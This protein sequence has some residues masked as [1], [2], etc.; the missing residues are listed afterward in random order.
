M[1]NFRSVDSSDFLFEAVYKVERLMDKVFDVQILHPL[2]GQISEDRKQ[3]ILK[4]C[5]PLG[6]NMCNHWDDQLSVYIIQEKDQPV[7]YLY[8]QIYQ[9]ASKIVEICLLSKFLH[10]RLISKIFYFLNESNSVNV[11]SLF[12]NAPFEKTNYD[13]I[14]PSPSSE[15]ICPYALSPRSEIA[16]LH[17]YF[18]KY[19]P[20]FYAAWIMAFLLSN[21]RILVISS[22]TSRI[23][24]TIM[25]ILSFFYPINSVCTVKSLICNGEEKE[26]PHITG[27][28][29]IGIPSIIIPIM[30]KMIQKTDVILNCD[31]PN[32]SCDELPKF[33][34][35][36]YQKIESFHSSVCS[37]TKHMQPGFPSSLILQQFNDFFISFLMDT[38]GVPSKDPASF[39]AP[40]NKLK[41]S[42]ANTVEALVAKS[43]AVKELFEKT[44]KGDKEVKDLFW[45]QTEQKNDLQRALAL[46][47]G[48]YSRG[49]SIPN[50]TLGKR[51]KT[52]LTI[53]K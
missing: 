6:N 7:K 13:I 50:G 22:H 3:M 8:I 19:Y 47:S 23:T 18:V 32:L 24:Q 27:P 46:T 11:L 4:Y 16:S 17:Q 12:A 45:N 1:I 34:Q 9:S 49:Q 29:I 40:I 33:N 20:P 41:S 25:S 5:F 53:F 39:S 21:Q 30:H 42:S 36:L 35:T 2:D 37:L 15:Y 14:C 31:E 43:P 10:I 48:A 44:E 38:Y 26:I 51:A 52:L 28:C